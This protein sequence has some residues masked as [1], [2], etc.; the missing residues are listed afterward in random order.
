M[1]EPIIQPYSGNIVADT[2]GLLCMPEARARMSAI[3][4][5]DHR[6]AVEALAALRWAGKE[7]HMATERLAEKHD[8]SEG[9]LQVLMILKHHPNGV[10]LGELARMG[11]TSA[12]N[13]TW[14]IDHLE[15][16]GLVV[17]VQDPSDRRSVH[18]RLSEGGLASIEKV[19]ESVIQTQSH[20]TNEI[21]PSEL[22]QFRHL[23]LRMVESIRKQGG[24][25]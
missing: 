24:A 4:D 11:N 1:N 8:L 2:D 10:A 17:R 16:D 18:A 22:D 25:L 14:L 23:C 15:Q 21:S 9:R 6:R 5:P 3:T 20:L 19:W 7:L 13:M 12:R